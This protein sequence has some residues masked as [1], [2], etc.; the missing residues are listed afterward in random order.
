MI[1]GY[2]C[3][4]KICVNK[5]NWKQFREI[6]FLFRTKQNKM[7]QINI[8]ILYENENLFDIGKPVETKLTAQNKQNR[9]KNQLNCYLNS[10]LYI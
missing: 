1:S 7:R 2:D 5:V 4:E 10:S 9:L 6:W 3:F 8:I